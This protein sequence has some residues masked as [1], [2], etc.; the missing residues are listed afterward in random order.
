MNFRNRV[1]HSGFS[2]M[3]ILIAIFIVAILAMATMPVINRQLNKAEEYSYYLAYNTVEK[4]AGQIVALGDPEDTT[5]YNTPI[6]DVI[7]KV[8][9]EEQA[10]KYRAMNK[11]SNPISDLI[12]TVG[13]KFTNTQAYILRRFV[14]KAVAETFTG[15]YPFGEWSSST[16]DDLWLAYQVCGNGRVNVFPKSEGSYT[17]TEVD[18]TTGEETQNTVNTSTH[19]SRYDFQYCNG[20]TGPTEDE[21]LTIIAN[22][23]E[24]LNN[25]EV[26]NDFYNGEI[27]KVCTLNNTTIANALMANSSAMV[28]NAKSFCETTFRNSC[29]PQKIIDGITYNRRAQSAFFAAITGPQDEVSNSEDDVEDNITEGEEAVTK[30]TSD[31]EGTCSVTYDYTYTIQP[32][33]EEQYNVEAPTFEA[34]WCTTQGYI[35]MTNK[36]VPHSIDCQCKNSTLEVS[37][38]SEKV[39]V[40][41]CVDS[42]KLPYAKKN[43]SGKY[44]GTREC[45]STDFNPD[46]NT[47]CPEKSLYDPASTSS[48]KCTCVSG[49]E[50]NSSC[51]EC[52][53]KFCPAGSHKTDD[54]VC[55]VN[56]PITQAK[57]FCELITEHWNISDSYCGSFDSD[58]ETHDT[59][60]DV[61][62]AALNKDG[63]NRFLS[64]NSKIG[65]FKS[66][67]P[68][69]EFANGLKLWILGDKAAS[70]PGLSYYADNI[71]KTQ[72]M[73]FRKELTK[74]TPLYC[75]DAGGY[76]CKHENVCLV[77]DQDSKDSGAI[78]D[79]RTCCSTIDYSSL[80]AAA[81]PGVD[82]KKDARAY[83]VAGFT[84]FVDIDGDKGDGTLWDDVYPFFI[85][86]NG[87]VYPAYPLDAPKGADAP[88]LL[89]DGGNSE[90]F[91]P[92]DVYYYLPT[93]EA[94]KRM[95]AFSGVS[96]ARGMCSA[97]KVSKYAPY[98]LNL[99][100]QFNG[101]DG[102]TSGNCPTSGGCTSSKKLIG[103]DY[104]DVD[105]KE[106]RN[107]CDHYN[108]FVSVRKKLKSF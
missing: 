92:V 95:T 58:P 65:A 67:K 12:A 29:S 103:V 11:K 31:P 78:A 24:I 46:S 100:L 62:N 56:P 74:N 63:N 77:L 80:E 32:G 81:T 38:N 42:N 108:C 14:P 76:F 3:E 75:H 37:T 86:S 21:K 88:E 93:D 82:W 34:N 84:V 41:K 22:G 83:A 98:C 57:R 39:C 9:K 48:C 50:M 10:K 44:D 28:P 85:G 25:H 68:N 60:N 107:P 91:L 73:C 94:R 87:T 7:A 66:I 13:K 64:V 5:S 61:Y 30:P 27:K 43:S 49:Y 54:G 15:E 70:I 72:N 55:V 23:V 90:K 59:Y 97:R 33:D 79:A 53:L 51:S 99:G 1:K 45:C 52:V 104:L 106:S 16:Y 35:N 47:C 89:Y 105:G 19:Y 18:E 69:I 17:E 36:G 2:L 71:S 40:D 102:F 20:Y 96:Y 101:G 26:L 8:N 6:S 4:L